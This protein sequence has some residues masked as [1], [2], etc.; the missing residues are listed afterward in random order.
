MEMEQKITEV[1][2]CMLASWRVAGKTPPLVC[3]HGAGVSSREILPLLAA[4]RGKRAA[5]SVDLPGYGAS[6]PVRAP[7][8]IGV[9]ADALALFL[10]ATSAPAV[11]LLGCSSGCQVAVDLTVRYPEHVRGL[12]LVGPTVDARARSFPRQLGR[13]VR[14]GVHEPRGLGTL[15]R[16]DYRD[17]G[18]QRVAAAFRAALSDLIEDKLP[19]VQQPTL[20]VRGEYDRM[21]PSDWAEEVTRLLPRG[22]LRTWPGAAHMV[23]F[24]DPTG[25]ADALDEFVSEVER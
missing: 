11:H 8:E 19:K 20:V 14:N 13:W 7:I 1:G 5:W 18:P 25:L 10:S 6:E 3:L 23:P 4:L 12:V 16:R 2:G 15:V 17:A 22:R 9:F 21:V 24:A